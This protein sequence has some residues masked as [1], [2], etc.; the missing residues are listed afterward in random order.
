[1]LQTIR[2]LLIQIIVMLALAGVGYILYRCRKITDEAGRCIGNILIYVS[3]PAVIIR[4]FLLERTYERMAGLLLSAVMAA[5]LLGLSIL[6]ARALFRR[7]P[8]AHFAAAFSNPSFFGIP[9]IL[10]S[11]G[12]NAVFYVAFFSA[13]LNMLQWTYGVGLMTGK[14]GGLKGI[15]KA[16]FFVALL[17]GLFLFLTGIPV[18]GIAR[19]LIDTLAGTCTPLAMFTVGIYLA[20]TTPRALLGKKQNYL[21]CLA[22]LVITPMLAIPLLML[23]P[24]GSAQLKQALLIAVSCPVGSNVAVYA[25]LHNKDYAYAVETVVLSALL[26]LLTIPPIQALGMLAFG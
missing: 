22:R 21:V 5:V 4:S 23:L 16:P 18:P 17:V 12:E 3:L 20:G 10:A 6:V 9:L 8:I 26:S 14:T 7:D 2:A 24:V 25:Q 19:S 11:L 13:L 15:L 1:M